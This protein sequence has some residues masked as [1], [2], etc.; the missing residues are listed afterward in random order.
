MSPLLE[1]PADVLSFVTIVITIATSV[2]IVV[3]IAATITRIGDI[4]H[5]FCHQI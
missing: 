2:T 4:V 5:H 1:L 3:T